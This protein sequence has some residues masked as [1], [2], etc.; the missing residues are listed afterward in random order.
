MKPMGLP[1]CLTDPSK[2]VVADTSVAI[3]LNA[4]GYA[5]DILKSL[6]NR[7]VITNVAY[8]ELEKGHNDVR[9]NME[10]I[11]ELSK[12]GLIDIVSLGDL[13]G[14]LFATLVSGPTAETLDDGESATI[15]YAVENGGIPLIDEK[16][17]TRICEERFSSLSLA[18]T[19]DVLAHESVQAVL[20][21]DNLSHAVFNALT[22]ARMRVLPHHNEWIISLIGRERAQSCNSLSRSLRY[23]LASN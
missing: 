14:T 23:A 11:A 10:I 20:G 12:Q 7:M 9:R 17:A 22:Q 1:S 18:C 4:T 13:A 15:A 21:R 6:P 5:A 16:K 3:N 19:V 8:G 2:L